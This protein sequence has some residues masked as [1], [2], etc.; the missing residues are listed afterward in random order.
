MS[1]AGNGREHSTPHVRR[2]MLLPFL[3]MLREGVEAA[4][5][6]GIV[7]SYLY[8]SSRQDLMPAVCA[9]I[10]LGSQRSRGG[11]DPGEPNWRVHGRKAVR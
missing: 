4:L 3:I 5:I 10:M 8:R 6:V 7:A 1:T 2:P 9:G 11:G